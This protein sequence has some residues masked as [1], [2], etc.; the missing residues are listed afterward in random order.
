MDVLLLKHFTIKYV[1]I[2]TGCNIKFL[3]LNPALDAHFLIS[4]F[5]QRLGGTCPNLGVVFKA[6][7]RVYYGWHMGRFNVNLISQE[8]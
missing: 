3:G 7:Y 4:D 2:Q 6:K 8:G 5:D 1:F